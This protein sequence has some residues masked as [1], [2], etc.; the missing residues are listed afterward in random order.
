[1]KKILKG[2]FMIVFHGWLLVRIKSIGK[3]CFI[4]VRAQINKPKYI[5]MADN[6]RIG[7]DTR[8][9]FYDEFNN[10]ALKPSLTF[11]NNVYI[12]NHFTV[13]CADAV[14]IED[15]VLM[16]SYIMISSENHGIDP[17]SKVSYAKQ[18]LI[19]KPVRIC[20]GVWLGEKVSILQGVTI[21]EKA[22]IG[23]GSVVTQDI[24]PFSIAVGMP[25][26][27]IEKYDF[28]EHCWKKVK[29]RQL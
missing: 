17:E 5:T 6:V 27:V 3:N 9:S 23:T 21:G 11:G 1:M 7:N 22:I 24:P 2:I 29:E 12:G 20:R 28:N 4:G 14:I 25:A 13:L 15:D 19:T 10:H 18:S 16:A 8:L 26:R